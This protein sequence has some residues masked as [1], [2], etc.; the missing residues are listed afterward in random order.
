MFRV[1]LIISEGRLNNMDSKQK[2]IKYWL[3]VIL[4]FIL[5]SFLTVQP[6][7]LFLYKI[8]HRADK[9]VHFVIYFLLGFMLI[10]ALTTSF[11]GFNVLF[12]S[13]PAIF[14]SAFLGTL[15]EAVQYFVPERIVDHSDIIANVLGSL[16]GILLYLLVKLFRSINLTR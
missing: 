8:Y 1:F 12:V 9:A 16:F 13:V 3:P 4:I 6:V 5:L 2:Y 14:L 15:A 7:P 11:S 10:R